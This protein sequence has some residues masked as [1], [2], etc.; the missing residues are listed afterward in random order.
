MILRAPLFHFLACV[1]IFVPCAHAQV[2]GFKELYRAA[3]TYDA[4]YRS[5]L[6]E[7]EA[8]LQNKDIAKSQLL[9]QIQ[10]NFNRSDNRLDHR[11]SASS[12]GVTSLDPLSYRSLYSGVSLRQAIYNR[13]ASARYK[14]GQYQESLAKL[15]FESKELELIVR[16]SESYINFWVTLSQLRFSN[17]QEVVLMRQLESLAQ[18]YQQGEASVTDVLDAQS[19]VELMKAQTIESK[20][21]HLV[22]RR[23]LLALV[24]PDF[25]RATVEIEPPFGQKL[26]S[27]LPQRSLPEWE[28]QVVEG[29][30]DLKLQRLLV[31]IAQEETKRV[32]AGHMPKAD[33]VASFAKSES[34]SVNLINQ[35]Y[36]SKSVG[37]QL[38]IPLY[39]GGGVSAQSAQA[40]AQLAKVQ[41]DADQETEKILMEVNRQFVLWEQSVAKTQAL[42]HALT[43]TKNLIVAMEKSVLGGVRTPLDVMQARLQEHQLKRDALQ[44]EYMAL[45]SAIRLRWLASELTPADMH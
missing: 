44:A 17:E 23:S 22:A 28:R 38:S 33:L 2:V 21:N 7:R 3:L 41:A 13:E 31:A 24:G 34:E 40:V 43:T 45:A 15:Q 16:L 42:N 5:A 6:Q 10:Y 1:C 18:Q 8:G 11:T 36:F 9:P 14:Q 20:S 25:L 4:Q 12:G 26:L 29:N 30:L 37:A 35:A 19:K 39:S 32:M 27:R